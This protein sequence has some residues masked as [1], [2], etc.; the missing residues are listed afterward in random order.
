MS[1]FAIQSPTALSSIVR[2][3]MPS[4]NRGSRPCWLTLKGGH[5]IPHPNTLLLMRLL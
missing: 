5:V 2:T 3:H 1:R 4:L